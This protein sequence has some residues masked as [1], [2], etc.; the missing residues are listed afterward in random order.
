MPQ[1]LCSV[2]EKDLSQA[3]WLYQGH[4]DRVGLIMRRNFDVTTRRNDRRLFARYEI[5]Y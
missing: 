1:G 5:G 4:C 2:V 3:G